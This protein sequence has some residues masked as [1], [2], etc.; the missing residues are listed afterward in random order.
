M[1]EPLYSEF[2][3]TSDLVGM[4]S[5]RMLTNC[6]DL[7]GHAWVI[8]IVHL[9]GRGFRIDVLDLAPTEKA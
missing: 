1:A 6:P 7:A 5:A 2:L 4:A 8:E 3:S 9:P